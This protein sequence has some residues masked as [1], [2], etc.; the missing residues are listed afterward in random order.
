MAEAIAARY[1]SVMGRWQVLAYI[2]EQRQIQEMNLS[3]V[4]NTIN[5]PV[6]VNPRVLL[7]LLVSQNQQ[8]P[9]Q[10]S[11]AVRGTEAAIRTASK[12]LINISRQNVRRETIDI[13]ARILR[14]GLRSESPESEAFRAVGRQSPLTALPNQEDAHFGSPLSVQKVYRQAPKVQENI[15]AVSESLN[16]VPVKG[17]LFKRVQAE[18][19]AGQSQMEI[20][21]LTDQVI[22]AIDRR[23]VTQRER[24][25]RI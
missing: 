4:N 17:E 5:S 12:E 20:D 23:I 22:Q 15:P 19:T 3:N 1:A 13:V 7:R 6:F 8:S 9:Q 14:Q 10:V 16:E 2:F 11:Q 24:M 18:R 25:G 21:R